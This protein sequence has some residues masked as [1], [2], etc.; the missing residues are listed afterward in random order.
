MQVELNMRWYLELTSN[1]SSQVAQKRRTAGYRPPMV[2][3]RLIS[4]V[5]LLGLFVL[6]VEEFLD[7]R[8]EAYP[9][10]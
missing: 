5:C 4:L 9:L 10:I 8:E 3:R 1:N 6:A 2:E 7:F